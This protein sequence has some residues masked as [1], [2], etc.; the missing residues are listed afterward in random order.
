M[1]PGRH[2]ERRP[3]GPPLMPRTDGG[4]QKSARASSDFE[5]RF[6]APRDNETFLRIR[7]EVFL[8]VF[9]NGVLLRPLRRDA[10]PATGRLENLN[11]GRKR[12]LA[13]LDAR[14]SVVGSHDV[15]CGRTN[16]TLASRAPNAAPH[17]RDGACA[18]T[19]NNRQRRGGCLG[20]CVAEALLIWR[21]FLLISPTIAWGRGESVR[22]E[23]RAASAEFHDGKTA[24]GIRQQGLCRSQR[25]VPA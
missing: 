10:G 18:R 6:P 17:A 13:E 4:V 21:S 9:Q 14:H 11:S 7:G 20:D 24:A 8:T 22:S 3:V 25:R 2:T 12:R 5:L 16:E 1:H 15:R 19:E 23:R